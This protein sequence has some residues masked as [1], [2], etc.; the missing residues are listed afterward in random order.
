MTQPAG[1]VLNLVSYQTLGILGYL[2]A[3]IMGMWLV[4]SI[5]RSRHV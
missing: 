1:R 4:V 3:G 2:T 5:I